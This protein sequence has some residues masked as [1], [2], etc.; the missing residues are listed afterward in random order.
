MLRCITNVTAE[1]A[2][3]YP[4]TV[5]LLH[6]FPLSAAMWQPQIEALEKAGYGVIAPHAYGIEGSPEIAEWNFTDYAVELAQLLESLH[7]A[8]VTVVGLS[9]GGYQAFE[10]YRLYSNKVKS[11]VLCDTRAEADAPAARATREEFMKAV[12][13]TGSAEAIRRMV[14]NYFS[15]AAYGANSTLVAQ[16]EAIINKQSPEVINAAMRAIMLR[17]DATPLLGSISCPTLILNGEEDSMTTKETAATIQ[18]GINGS[19]LQLIAGA[20]HIANLEQPELF[21]QALLEHLSLLQ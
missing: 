12:A 21:N 8:S 14:P 6:A 5:L 9:M 20:G 3:R 1:T 15:P 11:L 4:I 16:V 10:F 17:A 19:T 13:S 18:A 7:I 2:G